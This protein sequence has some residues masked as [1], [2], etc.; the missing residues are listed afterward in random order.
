LT[1][2]SP[3]LFD[4]KYDFDNLNSRKSSSF[5]I[6]KVPASQFVSSLDESSILSKSLSSSL[7]VEKLLKSFRTISSSFFFT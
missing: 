6:Y 1:P 3:N 4:K 7:Q 5:L 2:S